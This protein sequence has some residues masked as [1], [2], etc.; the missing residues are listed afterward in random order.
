MSAWYI[1]GVMGFYPVTPGTD[2][3]AIGAPQFP[4]MTLKLT[5]GG[6]P[7]ELRIIARNLSE[8]NKYIQSVTLNG[9]PITSPFLRH[10]E[11]M[12]GGEL[13]FTMGD[14]PNH[15]WK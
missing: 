14:K 10:S 5:A 15:D 3:Y 4:E 8:E 12:T 9:R 6:K 2:I 13:L 11:L 1:F 7:R